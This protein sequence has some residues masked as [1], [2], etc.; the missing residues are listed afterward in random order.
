MINTTE[1][2][3]AFVQPI[4]SSADIT[5]VLPRNSRSDRFDRGADT[6]RARISSVSRE[7]LRWLLL[8]SV[9]LVLLTGVTAVIVEAGDFA[10][11][12]PT[13]WAEGARR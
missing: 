10:V 8:G 2:I 1:R 11:D 5:E 13:G 6:A 9:A 7:W 3:P 4:R 12:W